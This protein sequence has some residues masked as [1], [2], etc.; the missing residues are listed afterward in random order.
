MIFR[1]FALLLF[2]APL[3]AGAQT[4]FGNPIALPGT[5]E[6]EDFDNG[7]EGLAYHDNVAGNAGAQYRPNESV[8][9]VVTRDTFG[10]YSVNNFDTGE[11][12]AYTVEIAQAG[13]Y[14]V[15]IR[16]A[17]GGATPTAFRIE[18]DGRNVTGS[19]SV[20]PT[21]GWS[22]YQWIAKTGV[23][24]PAGRH[25]L[26]LVSEQQWFDVNQIRVTS[27]PTTP[28]AGVIA[29]PGTFEAENFDNG[30]EGLAYHD[31]V[32]GNAGNQYRTTE[33]VD[34]QVT[35]DASGGSYSIYNFETGEWLLYTV[36]V[37]A[38][39]LYDID[40][41][42]ATG[43][44]DTTAFRIEVDGINVTGTVTL[45][46][47]GSF[48][49]YG[50]FGAKSVSLT[51][52][53]HVLKLVSEQQHFDVNQIRVAPVLHT[54]FRGTPISL[55]GT[56]EAED[57]DLGGQDNGYHDNVAGNAGN[58][59]RP[60]EDVDIQ[61]TRDTSGGGYS[62]YNFDTGEWLLYTVDIASAGRYDIEL[63]LASGTFTNT[64]F[65]V[66]LDGVDVTG[67][68]AVPA[69][70]SF[71]AYQWVGKAGV[72][73]PAGRH[74]LKLVS[75]QQWFDVNQ[76]RVVPASAQT[77]NPPTLLFRSGFEGSVS[78][79]APHNCDQSNCHQELT[80]TDSVTGST[81]PPI[82]G[83]GTADFAMRAG[84]NTN[85][86][87]STI[88]NYVV[89][90]IENVTG[91]KG[92]PTRALYTEL[93]GSCNGQ[94]QANCFTQD[95]YH[96]HHAVDQKTMY[97]SFWRKFQPD[98]VEKLRPGDEW[99]MVYEWK[100]VSDYRISA[101]IVAYDGAPPRWQ[102]RADN[103][104]NTTDPQVTYWR[105]DRF[106]LP[107]PI[108][109]WFKF[110]VF[111]H[112]SDGQ[113]GRVWMAVNGTVL[114]DKFGPNYGVRHEHIDRNMISQIY[115]GGTYPAY[116]WSDDYQIWSTFPSARE[117]DPWYDPPY[118]PH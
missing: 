109:E 77:Q 59:Y 88:S 46:A 13:Q 17:N 62:I 24:L 74:A 75:E 115:T 29:L 39:G 19:V 91:H 80:G 68:V 33:D 27:T 105:V 6:A 21:G 61:V 40:L 69:T 60:T 85:P 113:D 48:G 36:Q 107:V 102:L 23:S 54:P 99:F 18:I 25:V 76:I 42:V 114:V 67:S 66:E 5:F 32:A 118:A 43:T 110:E 41:R 81:W 47:T 45:P 63:R 1:L 94:G 11:W 70:G 20:P 82:I 117:G 98:L 44:S 35:R 15:A 3:A 72:Q 116:Q 37:A 103:V 89:N 51:A 84:S 52:G 101:Q 26:K 14:E 4:P 78:L 95:T 58:Q 104:A 92:T 31:N 73:L 97:I 90:R 38:T 8:D 87:P 96:L 50:W 34:I 71:G 53:Q 93:H 55:P 56:F 22:A 30:G 7:G 100:T 9:I 108:G 112:R 106:D 10:G 83:G 2:A 64:A 57:F 16:T 65:H 28:F 111:W 79:T 86:T 12:L 49:T